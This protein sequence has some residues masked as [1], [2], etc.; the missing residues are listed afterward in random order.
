M[1]LIFLLYASS[2]ELYPCVLYIFMQLL[3]FL[4]P[5]AK[6]RLFSYSAKK[7]FRP[8]LPA[9]LP[10]CLPHASAP[11]RIHL[12]YA[13]Y[14]SR[15][16]LVFKYETNTRYIRGI[17]EINTRY[18]EGRAKSGWGQCDERAK[19]QGRKSGW[20]EAEWPECGY[21]GPES[22]GRS[23]VMRDSRALRM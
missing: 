23:R 20:G 8:S 2:S 13:S 22:G 7:S 18:G 16:C 21:L 19:N 1:I 9:S 3:L 14:I 12:V 6:I 10:A 15:I 5:I 4:Y 17:Y 11:P